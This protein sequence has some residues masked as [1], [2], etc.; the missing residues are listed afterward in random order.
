M[1]TTQF[2]QAAGVVPDSATDRLEILELTSKL[3]LLVDA[4][5]WEALRR[6]FTDPVDFDYTSLNGGEPQ[7]PS[8]SDLVDGWRR[9]LEPL[10]S[11][12]HLIASQ[13]I[14]V[15][16]DRATCAASVQG[17]H[18]AA[19]AIGDSTFTVG[20]RYDLGLRRT[21]D[22]WRISALKLT[23][24]WTSGNRQVLPLGSETGDG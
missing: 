15:E 17:T 6:L 14:D 24:Q 16:R 10:V 20:G 9:A 19:G 7:S 13:V 12:Q 1:T 23:V 2:G 11:T 18:V 22:G 3:G 8:P 21:S 4:R 5:E